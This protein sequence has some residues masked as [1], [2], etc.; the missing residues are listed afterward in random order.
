MDYEKKYKE[1]LEKAKD[2]KNDII[3]HELEIGENIMDYIFPELAESENKKIR[4]ALIELVKYA[5]RNCFELLHKPFNIVSMDAMLTWLEKQKS[6]GEIVAR[7]KDSWYNEGKIAG[8]AEGLT[9]DE[10]Y[11]QGWHDALE[12]QGEKFINE[13]DEEIVKAVKDTSVLDMVSDAHHNTTTLRQLIE[14]LLFI[15]KQITN[16][17]IPVL[18]DG[19]K[20][21]KSVEL[22]QD[23][24]GNYYLNVNTQQIN[25]KL[26]EL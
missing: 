3:H 19:M 26:K 13:T 6:I 8:M 4:K 14:R 17:E 21:V 20:E 5:K 22:S 10:K 11:Q 15:G 9:D 24:E 16:C 23:N 25:E 2:Y 12:K 18:I 7:C 1:A